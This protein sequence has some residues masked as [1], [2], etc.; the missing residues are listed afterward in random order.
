VEK[1]AEMAEILAGFVD[2]AV[3]VAGAAG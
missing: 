2:V 1:A 3:E